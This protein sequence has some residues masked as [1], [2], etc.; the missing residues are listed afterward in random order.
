[1]NPLDVVAKRADYIQVSSDELVRLTPTVSK[2]SSGSG[3][4]GRTVR[5]R[6]RDR[7]RPGGDLIAAGALL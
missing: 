3:R 7:D 2:V 5:D 6:D 4:S 1:M